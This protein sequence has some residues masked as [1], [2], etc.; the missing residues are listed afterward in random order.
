MGSLSRLTSFVLPFLALFND[1]VETSQVTTM[2]AQNNTFIKR[3]NSKR[4]GVRYR[5][6]EDADRFLLSA[7]V[8]IFF[9]CSPRLRQAHCA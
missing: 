9:L 7:R 2:S 3:D 8:R 6:H 4:D 1:R 5:A